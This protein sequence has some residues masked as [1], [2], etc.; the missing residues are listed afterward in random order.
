MKSK[1]N[2]ATAASK[3]SRN[4]AAL[5]GV[6][7]G[8]L[9]ATAVGAHAQDAAPAPAADEGDIVIV[10]GF[11]NSLQTAISEKK[12]STDM[13]DVIKAEDIGQFPDLNLAESM[14]RIPGVSIDRDGGEGKQITVRGLNAE[15]SRT[16]L[17]GMEALATTGAKDSSGG[18]NRT[19]GFDFNVFAADLFNSITVRK[20]LSAEIEEGSLGAT[21][22]LQTARPFDYKGFTMAAGGQLG[23]NDLS[24]DVAKRGT[25]M[26]SNRWADG[27]LGALLSVAWGSRNVVEDSTN[28][29]R[30]ENS[31]AAGT[32][33]RFQS[34]STNGGTSF[35]NIPA[36]GPIA[37]AE[38]QK[39]VNGLHPRIPRYNHFETEQ[40]RLGVTGAF[41]MR[42]FEGTLISIDA[43]HATFEANRDEWEIEAISF[44]RTGQGL[45]QSDIYNY[46]I[47]DEGTI[48]K[49]SFNDV[50]IRSEH[51]FDELT[52]TFNQLN[53]TWD[54]N[55]GDRLSTKFFVGS[56]K[57]SQE[58]PEQTTF[59]F[60]SYNVDGYSYDYTDPTAPVF[61]YGK[62]STNCSPDQACYW[63]YSSSTA[64][65]DASLIRIR[66]QLVENEFKTTKFDVKFDLNDSITLKGGYSVK[67][68]DFYSEEYGRVTGTTA[69]AARDE[70][71]GGAI[72]AEIN[73]NVTKY[74]QTVSVGG[75]TYLIPNLDLIRDT[76]NYD[77]RCTNSWGTFTVNKTNASSR[78]NNRIAN[79]RDTGWFVQAD[80]R[81]DLGNMPYRGN[82]GLREVTTDIEVS[83]Y[84][85][86]ATSV[87]PSGSKL[88]TVQRSYKDSLPSFNFMI[89]PM[90]NVYVRFATAKTMARPTLLSLTPG[91]GAISTGA[92]TITSGNPALDP[93]RA[94]TM[95]LSFEWYPD[96]DTLFTVA[97]FQKDI[98]SY[99][100]SRTVQ[101]KLSELGYNYLDLGETSDEV[102][103]VTTPINTPGGDLKG[104]EI[105]L[106]KPFTFL[107]GFLSK[108][109][110][111]INYTHVESQIQYYTTPGATTTTTA[112][113]LGLS[114]EA[115]NI[116]AYY[117]GDV[118]AG[119]VAF[120][121]RDGYLSQLSPGSSAD[122]WGKNE[123][124]NIDAQMTW[125]IS[126]NLTLIL[127]GINL[128]DEADDRFISYNTAQGN[129]A[130]DLL[131]DYSKSGRQYYA[132]FRWKY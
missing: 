51:R 62:S 74:S 66:P 64:Q 121:Y 27:K 21:V 102:Y 98:K 116:T 108:T 49:A 128:T 125:K 16:R 75:N 101:A 5:L 1:S 120:A 92:N 77:C 2:G 81:G 63:T 19:R 117:E 24:E 110:G 126:K 43:M 25:F 79:E 69:N 111:I 48:T 40:N 18:T 78:T 12:K 10:T 85:G 71:A 112:N 17:N 31:S 3:I 114:P 28:S 95:D 73:N 91:G 46:T 8:V 99:I 56:S 93:V 96:R 14:Q 67:E 106:Q 11:R 83:G 44:S 119:R 42:P 105:S 52:T 113:L 50:D 29:T 9:M 36:T 20:S 122:F 87:N 115:W 13:V 58:T 109:G 32:A 127:E 82:I 90:E 60:E 86:V 23:Y 72:V 132:G 107:P 34:Y 80:F 45:P 100:Q 97:L 123:T 61:N 103:N 38:A 39:V 47:D 65:G 70:N 76:F 84:V 118:L 35:I 129:T 130:Q 131:Y 59:T 55:W 53:L 68:Y 54:Q 7:L 37:D 41:Q 33:G 26:I 57:S 89:E 30:W 104:Y 94:N 124:F 4:K 88:T 15:F 6:S 22:D